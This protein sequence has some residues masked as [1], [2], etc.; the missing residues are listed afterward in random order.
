M[1]KKKAG[2]GDGLLR[3]NRRVLTKRVSSLRLTKQGK[4]QS[5]LSQKADTAGQ[6]RKQ[7]HG[8]KEFSL[9]KESENI[10]NNHTVKSIEALKK[11]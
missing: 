1:G 8:C 3:K 5:W 2:G 10:R 9:E 7:H 4:S 6:E 11:N